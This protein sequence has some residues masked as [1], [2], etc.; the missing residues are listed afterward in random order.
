MKE[1]LLFEETEELSGNNWEKEWKNMPEYNN[2]NEEDPKITVTFKF[3]TQED[4]EEF[5]KNIKQY[6][7]N[8]EKVFEGKQTQTKKS[9][10]YPLK[11]RPG[12]LRYE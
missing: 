1:K 7:F 6:I 8:N 9:A 3:R 2:V 5:H 4:Y 10:W 12:N 11:Q